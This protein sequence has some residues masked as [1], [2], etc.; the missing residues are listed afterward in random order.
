MAKKKSIRDLFSIINNFFKRQS[1]C[2]IEI[3]NIYATPNLDSR[4]N[5]T[6]GLV[7]V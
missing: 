6:L 3:H 5:K 4:F 7:R 2:Y 1:Q